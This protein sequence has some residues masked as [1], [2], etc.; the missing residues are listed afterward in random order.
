MISV[1]LA[2]PLKLQNLQDDDLLTILSAP[3][4]ILDLY[5]YNIFSENIY[6]STKEMGIQKT[7][8]LLTR[9]MGLLSSSDPLTYKQGEMTERREV[10]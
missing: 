5:S 9:N 7:T 4:T 10:R 1:F 6:T 2:V 3:E 8:N